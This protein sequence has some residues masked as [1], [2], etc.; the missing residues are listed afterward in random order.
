MEVAS[1]YKL[2]T[3]FTLLRLFTLFK[4]LTL[5]TLLKQWHVCP[6]VVMEG[7]NANGM[8][9]ELLIKQI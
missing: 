3:L 2:L 4:L 5:L 7:L 6:Y 1:R 8:A 9:D